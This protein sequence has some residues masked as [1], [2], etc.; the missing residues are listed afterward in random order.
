MAKSRYLQSFLKYEKK[1]I[2]ITLLLILV[3]GGIT[4]RTFLRSPQIST[5]HRDY[6]VEDLRKTMGLHPQILQQYDEIELE[7]ISR[8]QYNGLIAL[9]RDPEAMVRIYSELKDFQLFYDIVTEYGPHHVIP[10]LDYFYDEGNVSLWLEEQVWYLW[11]SV[12]NQKP[13]VDTL[14]VRQKRLI[15]ILN[16]IDYQ[17][18][19]FLGRFIYTPEGAKRNYVATTTSSIVNFFTGGLSQL[20]VAIATRGFSEVTTAELVDAG[21]DVLVL[22]PFVAY[23]GRSTKAAFKS[24]A[25][26]GKAAGL[27]EKVLIGEGAEAAAKAGQMSRIARATGN[28]AKVIP[29]RTLFRFKYVKWYILAL[30]IAK[31]DLLN[32]A[33]TLVAKT[34]SIPPIIMKSGFWFLIFFP[35]LNLIMPLYYFVIRPIVRLIRRKNPI[36]A[37]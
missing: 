19:N 35:L 1:L 15:S 20:N 28:I 29:F 13:E 36:T 3:I 4:W 32:H 6:L 34:F 8:L 12:S 11:Q 5:I 10:A 30:A 21:I 24:V 33:A 23:L 17:K 37:S 9:D 22:V 16:E 14:S 18:H 25:G 26:G 31:P 2:L 27:T 7:I